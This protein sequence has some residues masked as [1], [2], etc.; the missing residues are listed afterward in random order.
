MRIY[1]LLGVSL[2]WLVL[3]KKQK[4]TVLR[5]TAGEP[6]KS[7]KEKLFAETMNGTQF[8]V[9]N[10]N[11]F[12]P[13]CKECQ[14]LEES[15][16]DAAK[17]LK[18]AKRKVLFASVDADLAVNKELKAESNVSSIPTLVFFRSGYAISTQEGYQTGSHIEQ[19]VNGVA[20]PAV[21]EFETQAAFDKA[22][23]AREKHE[24]V[25]AA[26][27]G[28]QLKELLD[29]VAMKGHK[30]GWGSKLRYLFWSDG[31]RGR[32]FAAVYR[33]LNEM[34]HFDASGQVSV[35][36]I[37]EFLKEQYVPIFS[38]VNAADFSS[39]FGAGSK[40]NVFVCFD[41]ASFEASVKKHTSAFTKAAKKF[42]SY[43]FSY[44]DASDPFARIISIQCHDYP[45]IFFKPLTKP[46][47]TYSKSFADIAQVLNEKHIM[48][49]MKESI[50]A[51]KAEGA[52]L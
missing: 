23:K 48:K 1:W 40:G 5:L 39:M 49:F 45:S 35:E 19:W 20:G 42:P 12:R 36:T 3:G 37:E 22:L 46:F 24:V 10:F 27:G 32:P 9:V 33:G 6:D 44:F 11:S 50:A 21:E 26:I 51:H 43:G 13:S 29:A 4:H 17:R 2:S 31:G 18:K 14:D 52:E 7:K 41:P 15:M 47:K 34:E 25:F 28:A 30:D 38:Q 8:A 16:K